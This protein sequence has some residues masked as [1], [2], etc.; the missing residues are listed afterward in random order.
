MK[1]PNPKTLLY[2]VLLIVPGGTLAVAGIEIYK[3]V[4]RKRVEPKHVSDI[5]SK[6]I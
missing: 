4:K 1:L 5:Q 6:D 3:Y 2:V